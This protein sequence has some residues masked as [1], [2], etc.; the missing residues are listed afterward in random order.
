MRVGPAGAW[1]ARHLRAW[2]SSCDVELA[3]IPAES[4]WQIGIVEGCIG[5][6]KECMTKLAL[7]FP[8]ME[9]QECLARCIAAHNGME[10][11]QG[12]TP[13]QHVLGRA[14][15]LDGRFW[16]CSNSDMAMLDAARVDRESGEA[17]ELRTAA[18]KVHHEVQGHRRPP[19][20]ERARSRQVK[21]FTPGK[22]VYYWR[23][24]KGRQNRSGLQ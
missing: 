23:R 22:L 5:K 6:V 13:Q 1:Q 20:A 11:V 3:P 8:D 16:A 7:E 15:D 19:R 9:P 4:H 12:F 18:E 2:L 17:H 24:G 10:R 21:Q 14:P